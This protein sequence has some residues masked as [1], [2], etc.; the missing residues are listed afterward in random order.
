MGKRI[1][2]QHIRDVVGECEGM[3]ITSPFARRHTL[4]WFSDRLILRTDDSRTGGEQY[5]GLSAG[6]DKDQL[7]HGAIIRPYLEDVY[8]GSD[9]MARRWTALSSANYRVV[10]DSDRR[11]G[12][13]IIEPDGVLVS[14]L[15]DAIESEGSTQQAARAFDI[16]PEAIDLA[17][18]YQEYLS[19]AA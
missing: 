12:M 14:A 2:L 17:I 5:I 9:K 18:K 7:Y 10:L 15:I 4:Y 13:P 19:P 11:F 1:S 3:G 6:V 16:R 8:Y